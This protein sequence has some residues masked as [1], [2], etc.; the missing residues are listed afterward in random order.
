[1]RSILLLALII[2]ASPSMAALTGPM[3]GDHSYS[4]SSGQSSTVSSYQHSTGQQSI[5]QIHTHSAELRRGNGDYVSEHRKLPP[6][7]AIRLQ[8]PATVIYRESNR[9]ALE[10]RA[11][12]NLLELVDTEV[13]NGTLVI[14]ARA[15]YISH[16][17]IL[18]RSTSPTLHAAQ[19]QGSGDLQIS[20]ISA[21]SLSLSVMGSGDISIAG[22]SETLSAALQGSGDIDAEAL[23]ADDCRLSLQGSGDIRA[24]CSAHLEASLQ[25]S[26]EIAVSGSPRV[27]QLS[28][29]GSGS[30]EID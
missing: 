8:L 21:R 5:Q 7:T 18:I 2:V 1:M 6:F 27:A 25:G 30:I 20:E 22:A 10:I 23:N 9:T 26:G 3:F 19:V 13:I 28:E 12:S 24:S 29:L 14:S 4:F 11:D 15:G 17:P 16:Q